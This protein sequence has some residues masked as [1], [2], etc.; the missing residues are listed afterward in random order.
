[1]LSVLPSSKTSFIISVDTGMIP[2]LTRGA[3]PS[4]ETGENFERKIFFCVKYISF[5]VC[6]RSSDCIGMDWFSEIYL[7]TTLDSRF[8]HPTHPEAYISLTKENIHPEIE[9]AL[10]KYNSK[11][12]EKE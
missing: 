1:M 2:S 3:A 4:I 8:L 5:Y 9:S 11:L 6:L 7:Q 10:K 12:F